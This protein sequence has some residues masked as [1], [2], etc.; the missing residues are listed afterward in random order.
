MTSRYYG[1]QVV[2]QQNHFDPQT[3][4]RHPRLFSVLRDVCSPLVMISCTFRYAENHLFLT[5]LLATSLAQCSYHCDRPVITAS[6]SEY[7]LG[8]L[9]TLAVVGPGVLLIR[10]SMLL[11]LCSQGSSRRLMV[12]HVL[13]ITS[14]CCFDWERSDCTHAN[15]RCVLLS[16]QIT[17]LTSADCWDPALILLVD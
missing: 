12:L 17:V 5:L 16:V 11:R 3:V 2:G 6:C 7:R 1:R 10:E 13:R 15:P 14:R 9:L 8:S 4:H